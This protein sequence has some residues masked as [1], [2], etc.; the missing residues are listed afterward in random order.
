N[1]EGQRCERLSDGADG[2]ERVGSYRKLFLEIAITVALR[3]DDLA[4]LYHGERHAGNLPF[5]HGFRG[6]VVQA[7]KF[8]G[9][10]SRGWSCGRFLFALSDERL[11]RQR[12]HCK[13]EHRFANS[14]YSSAPV[15][16]K[17][18]TQVSIRHCDADRVFSHRFLARRELLDSFAAN[19][20]SNS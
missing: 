13:H 5:L 4:I 8:L 9:R 17:Y 19:F 3:V 12:K 14:H 16:R 15:L 18:A 10:I 6:Q 7:S 2:K 11:A 1:S 20:I